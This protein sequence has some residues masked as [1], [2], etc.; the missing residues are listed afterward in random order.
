VLAVLLEHHPRAVLREEILRTIW[1]S[2]V[3]DRGEVKGYVSGSPMMAT[4]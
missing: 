2:H 4:D 1:P 3:V